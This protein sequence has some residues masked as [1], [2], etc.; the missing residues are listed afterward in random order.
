M[1]NK[2]GV[3]IFDE[4]QNWNNHTPSFLGIRDEPAIFDED[5]YEKEKSYKLIMVFPQSFSALVMKSSLTYSSSEQL[6]SAVRG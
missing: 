5:V 1:C 3:L 4:N 6:L 2:F